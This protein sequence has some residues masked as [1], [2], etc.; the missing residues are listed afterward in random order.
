MS[1]SRMSTERGFI[2]K[3]FELSMSGVPVWRGPHVDGGG[4]ARIG[5]GGS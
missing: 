1:S 4:G 3:T 5:T 2:M